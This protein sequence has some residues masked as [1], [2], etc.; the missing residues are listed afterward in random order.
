MPSRQIGQEVLLPAP[1][2]RSS[3]DEIISLIDW[4]PI[5]QQ[6][7]VIYSAQRGEASWPPLAMFRAML[8]AIWHDLSDVRLA[9]A[10]ND[11]APFRRFCGFALTEPTP[12]RTAFVRFRRELLRHGLDERLFDEITA[13][14]KGKAIRIKTGT[15]VDAT[16]VGSASRQ[17][18][19]PSRSDRRRL[20]GAPRPCRR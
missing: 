19:R 10:L 11:R 16:G 5:E 9:D 8:L 14:L 18:S 13:Q 20:D 2:K 12:E 3:L 1:E 6:L 15:M 7:D 17:H 4:A